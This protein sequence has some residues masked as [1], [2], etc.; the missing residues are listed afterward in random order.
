MFVAYGSTLPVPHTNDY[1]DYDSFT[2]RTIITNHGSS[3]QS[4]ITFGHRLQ[5][6]STHQDIIEPSLRAFNTKRRYGDDTQ[7]LERYTRRLYLPQGLN[8]NSVYAGHPIYPIP[9][10]GR[11]IEA[12]ETMAPRGVFLPP[13]SSLDL[14][15]LDPDHRPDFSNGLGMN[16][17]LVGKKLFPYHKQIFVFFSQIETYS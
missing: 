12:I 10:F 3:A 15:V 16:Y 9:G 1:N 14:N 17:F 2:Q 8:T 7:R 11:A 5:S 4:R 13:E 6:A